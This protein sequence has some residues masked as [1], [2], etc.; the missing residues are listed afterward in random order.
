MGDIP[1]FEFDVPQSAAIGKSV[2]SGRCRARLLATRHFKQNSRQVLFAQP[3]VQSGLGGCGRH[4][5]AAFCMFLK[6]GTYAEALGIRRAL[7]QDSTVVSEEE[8][9]D[10]DY[11]PTL[12]ASIEVSRLLRALLTPFSAF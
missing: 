12:G 7:K 10:A 2:G 6:K 5:E 4:T 1:S 3:Q 11:D 8:K 9:Y